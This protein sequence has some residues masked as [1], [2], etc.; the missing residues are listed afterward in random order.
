MKLSRNFSSAAEF[1]AAWPDVVDALQRLHESQL[2]LPDYRYEVAHEELQRTKTQPAPNEIERALR[3]F[4]GFD[5]RFFGDAPKGGGNSDFQ[6]CV[7]CTAYLFTD[8]DLARDI[9]TAFSPLLG[10]FAQRI[11]GTLFSRKVCSTFMDDVAHVLWEVQGLSPISEPDFFDWH[12][13][14]NLFEDD[15][16][17]ALLSIPGSK[18]L[19]RPSFPPKAVMSVFCRGA[20]D[21]TLTRSYLRDLRRFYRES[22]YWDI[23]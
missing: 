5:D 22:G 3:R 12:G 13:N 23:A 19:A 8:K 1:R 2:I 20:N 9:L 17:N 7:Y 18:P 11:F 15:V 21:P 16:R 6:W 14:L 4:W 10:T